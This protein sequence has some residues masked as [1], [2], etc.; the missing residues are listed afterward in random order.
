[1]FSNND[2]NDEIPKI[3]I[4]DDEVNLFSKIYKYKYYS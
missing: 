4:L 1:M 3:E 2:N